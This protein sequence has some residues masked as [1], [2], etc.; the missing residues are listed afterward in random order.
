MHRVM[1]LAGALPSAPMPSDMFRFLQVM[2]M[3]TAV[4]AILILA[5]LI[6]GPFTT[7]KT[8]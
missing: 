5:L 6:T 3:P 8:T 7:Q 1:I 4:R 2:G